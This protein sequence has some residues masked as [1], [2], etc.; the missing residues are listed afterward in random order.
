MFPKGLCVEG[1][2]PAWGGGSQFRCSNLQEV[3]PSEEA[4]NH[5]GFAFEE[6]HETPVSS[7]FFGLLP[8][9]EVRCASSS[10]TG[11]KDDC[12]TG[13]GISKTWYISIQHAGTCCINH[14]VY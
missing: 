2:L 5:L 4:A 9:E 13:V 8:G 14:M 12:F 11:K 10:Q 3:R 6:D 1:L 7:S